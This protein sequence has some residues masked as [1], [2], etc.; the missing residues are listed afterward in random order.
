MIKLK[1]KKTVFVLKKNQPVFLNKC[2]TLLPLR[3]SSA[4]QSTLCDSGRLLTKTDDSPKSQTYNFFFK[5]T[6]NSFC[7]L[8]IAALYQSR[9]FSC[10]N[11]DAKQAAISSAARPCRVLTWQPTAS[12]DCRRRAR[13]IASVRA[14]IFPPLR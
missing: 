12:D 14:T 4:C 5:Q 8:C 7:L 1:E 2:L 13:P 6:P 10:A 9:H 3:A 11:L